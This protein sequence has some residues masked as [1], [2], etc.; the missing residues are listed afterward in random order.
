MWIPKVREILYLGHDKPR[1]IC[2]TL[3]SIIVKDL[4]ATP[5]LMKPATDEHPKVSDTSTIALSSPTS[6]ICKIQIL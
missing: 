3:S 5:S 6:Y 1:D 4:T 2:F